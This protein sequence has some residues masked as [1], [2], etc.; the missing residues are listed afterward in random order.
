[1][2]LLEIQS[3]ARQQGSISRLLSQEFVAALQDHH[4]AIEHMQRDVGSNPPSHVN[5]LWT[6]A[7]YLPTEQR[8]PDMIA[9]LSESEDLITELLSA[10]YLLLGVPMYNF[11]VPATFKA[12]IDNI[13]RI[14]RTFTFDPQTQSFAGLVTKTKA[15]IITPSAADFTP[16]TPMAE[17]NFCQT[18]LRS[19]LNFLGIEDITVV[20]IPNQFMSAEIRDS[21][22]ATARHKLNT[23]AKNW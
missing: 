20:P 11:S 2:K 8:T 17:M 13:V 12:Y 19:L 7:N 6:T 16:G 10:D 21:E 5:Q 3:S 22:I 9:V 23:L 4:S 18:Y 15:L 14:N 1:M